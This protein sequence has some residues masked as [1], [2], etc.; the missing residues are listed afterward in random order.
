MAGSGTRTVTA[1]ADGTLG[2]SSDEN[3]KTNIV[4]IADT[5]DVISLLKDDSIYPIFYNLKTDIECSY[6]E[7]GFTAQMFDGKVDGLTG[8]MTVSGMKYLNYDRIVSILWQQNK[9]L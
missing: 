4:P 5:L 6:K 9:E 3:L 2:A 8:T 1:A 7:I